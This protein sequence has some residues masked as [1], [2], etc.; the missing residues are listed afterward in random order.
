MEKNI[1]LQVV[2]IR[3]RGT[4][5]A[6][7]KFFQTNTSLDQNKTE[8]DLAAVT[9]EFRSK[10]LTFNGSFD[11]QGDHRFQVSN[12]GCTTVAVER[13]L[14][15]RFHGSWMGSHK[16]GGFLENVLSF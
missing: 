11:T 15:I 2:V 1:N 6:H 5:S 16:V 9:H 13:D 12:I 8:L 14:S 4:Y 7:D 10:T 3:N